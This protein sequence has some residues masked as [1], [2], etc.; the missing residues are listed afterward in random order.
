M[1]AAGCVE[2]AADQRVAV[3]V[4]AVGYSITDPQRRFVAQALE[5]ALELNVRLDAEMIARASALSRYVRPEDD[6]MI[7]AAGR[8]E[9]RIGSVLAHHPS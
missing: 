4:L 1:D 7:V 6:V 5:R 2:D 9:R 8:E 3:L